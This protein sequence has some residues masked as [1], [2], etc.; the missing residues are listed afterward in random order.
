[1]F[2][3]AY[4]Y[5]L[6]PNCWDEYV[7]IQA[8]ASAV[9][10]RFIDYHAVYLRNNQDPNQ[11][12]ELDFFPDEESYNTAIKSVNKEP[13]ID[14]LFARFRDLLADGTEI[15]AEEYT[16]ILFDPRSGPM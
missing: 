12:T 3:K 6:R 2:V 15:D 14:S 10:R 9:Y 7:A 8:Q 13:L 16:R 1:M 5:R 4:R 11:I